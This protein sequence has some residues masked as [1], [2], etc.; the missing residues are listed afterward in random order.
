MYVFGGV[1]AQYNPTGDAWVYDPSANSWEKL[2]EAQDFGV[3]TQYYA[4]RSYQT[5][6]LDEQSGTIYI[7]GGDLGDGNGAPDVLAYNPDT[8]TLSPAVSCPMEMGRYGHGSFVYDGKLYLAFGRSGKTLKND[9]IE[10]DLNNATCKTISPSGVTPDVLK[11]ATT[12]LVDDKV[13]FM[14]GTTQDLLGDLYGSRKVYIYHISTGSMYEHSEK[15]P[16]IGVGSAALV[17][18]PIP[19]MLL[20]REN[21][22]AYYYGSETEATWAFKPL[23]PINPLP[24]LSNHNKSL[25]KVK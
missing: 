11:F 3:T 5:A 22:V 20:D 24:S 21:G 13:F 14:G 17:Y 16:F 7:S 2:F 6:T 23:A 12:L 15:M 18:T 19:G 10:V 1:D 8:N 25:K 4:N 9:I